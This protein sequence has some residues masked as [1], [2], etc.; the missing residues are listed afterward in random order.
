M[1]RLALLLALAIPLALAAC[2]AGRSDTALDA[3]G[4]AT[5]GA[6]TVRCANRNNDTEAKLLECVTLAGVQRHLAAFQAIADANGGTR[7]D[8][9]PGY[10]ASVDYVVR[11]LAAAGYDARRV[12]FSYQVPDEADLQQVAPVAATYATGGFSGSGDGDV[13]A[14]VVAVDINLTPPRA[15]T[16]GC[17]AADFAGFPA[18]AVALIQRSGVCTFRTKASNAQAAGASAAVIFNQG[19][20]PAREGLIVSSLGSPALGIPVVGA[21]FADGAALAQPGSVARVRVQNATV[22]SW[23]VVA[24]TRGGAS[25]RVV[26]LGGHLDSV[27]GGPGIQDNGSGSAALLET[28]VMM[29]KVELANRVRFA[30]WGAEERG[31]IGSTAYVADLSPAEL[32]AVAAYLNFDMIGSPNYVRFVADGDGSD[33]GNPGPAGSGAIEAFLGGFYTARGL[34]FEP[35][36]LDNRSD[37]APFALAG[38]PVGGLFTGAEG[39]KTAAQ[40]AVYGGTAGV[41]LDPCYHQACDTDANVNPVVLDLNADAL[42]ASALHFGMAADGPRGPRRP[43]APRARAAHDHAHD[44][45]A[46]AE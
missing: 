5:A 12:P 28:A 21:S 44:H 11:T 40:A 2:D 15:N 19:N 23:N 33:T 26:I 42:A 20:T 3:G 41:A 37:Y 7:A 10:E 18:V 6:A 27:V 38:I 24:E 16:S 22:T 32:D 13:T 45:G 14:A 30:W 17:Q 46:L 9:T 4:P 25:G 29:G 35:F 31:L 43:A 1:R 39:I 34:A 8:G 36:W